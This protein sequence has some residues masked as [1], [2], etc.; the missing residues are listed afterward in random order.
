MC[1]TG[2]AAIGAR[3]LDLHR[4]FSHQANHK[5]HL[6]VSVLLL[7]Q[8]VWLQEQPCQTVR[9]EVWYVVCLAALLTAMLRARGLMFSTLARTGLEPAAVETRADDLLLAALKDFAACQGSASSFSDLG[10]AH[11]FVNA[12]PNGSLAVSLQLPP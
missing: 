12:R 4:S 9:K 10:Q 6:S 1:C 2:A 11:P 8:H 5:T 3:L 7:P